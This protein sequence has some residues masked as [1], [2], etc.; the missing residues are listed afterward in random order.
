MNLGREHYD[1]IEA[2]IHDIRAIEFREG[3][4]RKSLAA[5]QRRLMLLA[6][7]D[8]LF[9]L[10]S[11]PP[12]PQEYERNNFLYRLHE[13]AD[14]RFALYANAASRRVTTPVHNHTTWAVIVGVSG[15]ELNRLHERTAEGG[16][17]EVERKVIGPGCGIA[18]MPDDLHAIQIDHP[19][20]NFHLY[21]QGLEQLTQRQ[22]YKADENK[23]VFFDNIAHIRDARLGHTQ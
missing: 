18:F 7:R 2:A 6:Q 3:V 12:P 11:C 1:A 21:G 10:E 9:N 4:S 13:D 17:V 20:L 14:H 23:W 16:V 5:I 8:D 19:L 15:E 22:Y